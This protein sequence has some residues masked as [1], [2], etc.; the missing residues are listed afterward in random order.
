MNTP[1]SIEP[2][3][4]LTPHR[5]DSCSGNREVFAQNAYAVRYDKLGGLGSSR[6]TILRAAL[7]ALACLLPASVPT[8][9]AA[10]K[11]SAF[12]V[13]ETTITKIHETILAK[14]LT[15]TELMKLYLARI[16][17]AADPNICSHRSRG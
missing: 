17:A 12:V 13:E 9:S 16:K 1:A 10:E 2:W 7:L 6:S 5:A 15:S 3:S 8:A 11:K 4:S 14:K